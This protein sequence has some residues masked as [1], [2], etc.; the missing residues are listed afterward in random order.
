MK[1][2]RQLSL[3]FSL[4]RAQRGVTNNPVA[5]LDY[6]LMEAALADQG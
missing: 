6:E 2:N 1:K 4:R 5:N 3:G